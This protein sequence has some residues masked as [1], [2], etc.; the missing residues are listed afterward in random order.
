M[1][2]TTDMII[3]Q[4]LYVERFMTGSAVAVEV[5]VS[6]TNFYRWVRKYGWK[7]KR[8][9]RLLLIKELKYS[10]EDFEKFVD[11]SYPHSA[12]QVRKFIRNYKK[13]VKP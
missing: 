8:D 5:G 12:K 9:E 13:S 10:F 3:A 1:T 11:Q 7:A 6:K 4:R 2:K